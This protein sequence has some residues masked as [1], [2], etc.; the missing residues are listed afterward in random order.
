[1][2][3]NHLISVL[4]RGEVAFGG[5]FIRLGGPND[6]I[7]FADLD[8]DFVVIETE[9]EGFI[10]QQ[11]GDALQFLI[12]PGS[13]RPPATPL[14]RIPPNGREHNQ[15]FAKQ[16]LDQGSFG[17]AFPTI[18]NADQAWAAVT[19]SRYP[20]PRDARDGSPVGQRGCWLRLAPRYWGLPRDEYYARADLWPLNPAGEILLMPIIETAT[21]VDNLDSI[22][23][24]VKGIGA[25]WA[26]IGDMSFSLGTGVDFD[27]DT[28]E[29]AVADVLASCRRHNV[30]CCVEVSRPDDVEKRIA[31]GFRMIF[32]RASLK[33]PV[34]ERA[35]A[36]D[37]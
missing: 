29:V 36:L 16:A 7:A 22:L 12:K 8:Y 10:A 32:S 25:I 28:V 1:M 37:V 35:R 6:A 2:R 13:T 24:D 4:E 9:H 18:E 34:L 17:I 19:A 23:R 14:V 5:G 15:W 30:P 3:L 26:G 31:Q 20:Q 33:D 21:G 11:L 27:S